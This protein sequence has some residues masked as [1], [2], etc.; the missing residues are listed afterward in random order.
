MA[1]SSRD[2][3]SV[4]LRGMKAALVTQARAKGATPSD[5]VR[6]LLADALRPGFDVTPSPVTAPGARTSRVRLSLR[7]QSDEASLVVSKAKVSGLPVGCYIAGLCADVP[8]L[9]N[10]SRPVD[11]A[12]A[13][14]TS[15]AELST[16]ARDLRHLT[17]LLRQGQVRAAQE[18]RERLDHTERD[19]RAHLAVAAAVMAE[20]RPIRAAIV[21]DGVGHAKE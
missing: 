2:R 11:L 8:A 14:V 12:A 18:Y 4:D 17:L 16:L 20:L 5:L 21:R 7:M 3:I 1:P 10:G 6:A 15:C 13:L 19:V 9:T